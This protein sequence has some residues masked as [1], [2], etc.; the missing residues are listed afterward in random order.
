M[1][2]ESA[3]AVAIVSGDVTRSVARPGFAQMGKPAEI[4][5]DAPGMIS[6]LFSPIHTL[7]LDSA[8]KKLNALLD[9]KNTNGYVFKPT[10][11]AFNNART[12]LL[13]AYKLLGQAY[14]EPSIVP[15]GEGGIDIEWEKGGKHLLLNC[16]ATSSQKDFLYYQQGTE[17]AAKDFSVLLFKEKLSW[18]IHDAR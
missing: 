13:L 4:F 16:Q 9:N 7:S 5:S 15:D 8:S 17:Y 11:L 2:F 1:F 18:L 6:Q 3:L 12:R 14:F 10:M